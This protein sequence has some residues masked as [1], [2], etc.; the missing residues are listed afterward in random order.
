MDINNDQTAVLIVV[1]ISWI[2]LKTETPSNLKCSRVQ[3]SASPLRL[4]QQ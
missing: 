3:R 1:Y 2:V 4:K